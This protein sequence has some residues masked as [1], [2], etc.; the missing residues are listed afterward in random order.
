VAPFTRALSR[1][2]YH[3][4]NAPTDSCFQRSRLNSRGPQSLD[5][6]FDTGCS[7]LWSLAAVVPPAPKPMTTTCGG[8]AV[9]GIVVLDTTAVGDS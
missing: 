2:G 8:G 7:D 3:V 5:V 6:A 1:S 4:F 9:A